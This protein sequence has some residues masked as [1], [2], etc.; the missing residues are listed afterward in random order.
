MI[1]TQQGIPVAVNNREVSK[2]EETADLYSTNAFNSSILRVKILQNKVLG[3]IS[4]GN[5]YLCRHHIFK[6]NTGSHDKPSSL[7]SAECGA[8]LLQPLEVQNCLRL[9]YTLLNLKCFCH[10]PSLSLLLKTMPGTHIYQLTLDFMVT[11]EW[12]FMSITL[13]LRLSNQSTNRL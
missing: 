11:Q 9:S 5:I 13:S 1:Y 12:V 8:F 7:H 2:A 4:Q 6:A 10:Y 3:D